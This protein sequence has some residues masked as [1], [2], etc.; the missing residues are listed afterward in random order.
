[1]VVTVA[2]QVSLPHVW[3]ILAGGPF[4]AGAGLGLFAHVQ[5]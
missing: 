3:Q 2:G 5:E 4:G 1:M